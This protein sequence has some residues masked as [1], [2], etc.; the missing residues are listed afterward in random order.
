MN[1]AFLFFFF[2]TTQVER[3]SVPAGLAH[4]VSWDT[5]QMFL[6]LFFFHFFFFS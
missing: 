5:G 4:S 6:F 3:D 1:R 2:Y